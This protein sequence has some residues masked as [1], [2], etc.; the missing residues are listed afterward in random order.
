MDNSNWFTKVDLRISQEI[1]GFSP[2]QKGTFYAVIENVGN[3]LN[4]DWG[5]FY[6]RGF[7]RTA[8]IVEASLN[9]S[10]QYVFENFSPPTQSRVGSASLWS[11]RFGVNYTFN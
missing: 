3:L 5:V 6:E 8:G 7:P 4:D 11:L 9:G 1:P 10:N 2:E